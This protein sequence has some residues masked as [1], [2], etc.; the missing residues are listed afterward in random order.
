MRNKHAR[1]PEPVPADLGDT[2]RVAAADCTPEKVDRM[3]EAL[4]DLSVHRTG[5]PLQ[6]DMS[7]PAPLA[8]RSEE[9]KAGFQSLY[10]EALGKTAV[11]FRALESGRELDEQQV[12]A[13]AAGVVGGLVADRDLALNLPNMRTAH[14][15]LL[16]HSL[17]V[18]VLSA[19]VAASMGYN[20][21]QVLGMA[22]AAYLHDIGMLKVPPEIV[23]RA[24]KLTPAELVQVRHHPVHSLDILQRLVGRRSGIP[25]FV[26]I[27]AYQ[28]HEC[29]DGS[30][31][32]KGRK[33]CIIHDFARILSVCDAYEAMT[34]RRAWREPLLPY[35]AM[36]QVISSASRGIRS[37]EVVRALLRYIS[38]F[39]IG[40]W[41][42]LSDGAVARVVAASE[43]D[44]SRPAVSVIFRG[45][46]R[47][48]TP[49]R[50]DLAA[51]GAPTVVRPIPAPE[52][53]EGL[54]EGF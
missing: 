14:D 15:Y 47:T 32:P 30:G 22:F 8:A 19:S 24:G 44:F 34:S 5:R 20:R 11:I 12:G 31:Y 23:G 43:S 49:E 37:R 13:L 48:E 45:G 38:L 39:P 6:E 35:H 33:A 36:E 42:E 46:R 16:G 29:E 53:V 25:A 51:D 18:T 9:S 26:P 4:D 41:V 7:R 2:P 50:L 27:V 17:G 52:G 3:I 40:S 21:E 10:E 28:T 1:R 54:M